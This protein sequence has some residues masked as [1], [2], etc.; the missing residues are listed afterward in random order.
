[1]GRE[2]V[3][4]EG[5]GAVAGKRLDHVRSDPLHFRMHPDAIPEESARSPDGI[6]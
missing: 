3:D 4:V 1:M 5:V 2:V 6:A